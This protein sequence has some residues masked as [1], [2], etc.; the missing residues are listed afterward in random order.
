MVEIISI[1]FKNGGKEYYFNPNGVQ[2]Q[3]GDGVIV[4][5]AR[6]TEYAQCVRGNTM[7]DEIELTAPLRPVVRAATQEDARTLEKNKERE[8]R[9][10]AICQQKIAEHGLDM[11][12]VSA[13]YSFDGSKILFFFTSDGRVDF[14]ALVKDLAS[15]L[16]TRIELR[17]IGVR[18]EAKLLGG[19]GICG[20]PFC[21]SQ[22]L[23]EF[24]PV[25]IKMA[26]TQNLSLNPTKISGTC[27]RL[28]CCL[29]F[30]QDAYEDLVK[31]APKQ[32]S[33]VETPDG[34][35]T[36]TGINL[37]RQDLSQL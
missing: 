1:R 2:F 33:F 6:G 19:L 34:A 24:Q 22:F 36:V 29:K 37:L 21:C 20:K 16:H 27:G 32:E 13:E 23:E 3:V 10:F 35:G 30:E 8:K 9:A 26:K 11:K 15:A 18:D 17:Q 28:M 7:I 31:H 12:L 25:S 5:T 14:R 4:E